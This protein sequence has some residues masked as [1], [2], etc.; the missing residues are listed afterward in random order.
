MPP[1]PVFI[2][3]YV[4]FIIIFLCYYQFSQFFKSILDAVTFSCVV[5]GSL[6]TIIALVGA[7]M[8]ALSMFVLALGLLLF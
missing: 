6:V 1:G 8:I 5:E 3:T 7:G 4:D 2:N